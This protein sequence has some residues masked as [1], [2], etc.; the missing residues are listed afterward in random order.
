MQDPRDLANQ[1]VAWHRDCRRRT[2][3]LVADLDESELIGPRLPIVNPLR[4]EVGH[5]AWFLELWT[6]RRARGEQPLIAAGD[7]LYD[8][9]RVAHDTRW[10]L[11]LPSMTETLA[12]A[13]AVLERVVHHVSSAPPTAQQAYFHRL[14]IFHEDMHGEAFTYTRQTLGYRRPRFADGVG[15]ASPSG[16]FEG[17]VALPGGELLLGATEDLPFVFDNEKWAHSVALE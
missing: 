8:S 13:A 5:V 9:A 14:A 12:Y 10:A 16:P 4:W 11:R 17:D 15:T 1:L 2:L 7:S 6:L 3:A